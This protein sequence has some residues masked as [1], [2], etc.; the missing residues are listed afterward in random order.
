MKSSI[1]YKKIV[2]VQLLMFMLFS[3]N[4]QTYE[5]E[6]LSFF[7]VSVVNER[8]L[9]DFE[10]KAGATC[11]GINLLRSEDSINY[12]K[13]DDIPGFCGS[14]EKAIQYS[15]TDNDPPR[16]KKIFYRL[17]FGADGVSSVKAVKVIQ[18]ISGDYSIFPNPIVNSSFLY[19][20][21]PNNEEVEVICYNL[22][23]AFILSKITHTNSIHLLNDQFGKGIV[24]FTLRFTGS[25]KTIKGR[26][27][28]Q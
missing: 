8:V 23:G 14:T 24:F 18:L 17:E 4:S 25:G 27:L 13:I 19:F 5:H 11:F 7:N 15:F 6:F 16:N 3:A 21:N 12:N 9:L 10:M 1:L 20:D 28:V 22:T 2:L 26:F